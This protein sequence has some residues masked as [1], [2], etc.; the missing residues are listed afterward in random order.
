MSVTYGE[1]ES[2]ILELL[3]KSPGYSGF[4]TERKLRMAVQD[5]FDYVASHM[6]DSITGGWVDSIVYL[7]TTS[8][9]AKVELPGDFAMIS[10]VR[11]LVNSLY[12][13]LTYDKEKENIHTKPGDGISQYPSRYK[14]LGNYLYFNPPL[15]VGGTE[16]LQ[17]EGC[18][19]PAKYTDK[20][21]LI[22]SQF[23]AAFRH[24]IKY[25]SASILYASRHN[26]AKPWAHLEAQWYREIVK[27]ID[28][29][30]NTK[31]KIKEF[32]G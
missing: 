3:Q 10:T 8:N 14:L 26:G 5:C 12:V 4:Y 13:P 17:V 2:D 6:F 22:P 25:R 24:F 9:Q 16:Y 29:R 32:E 30:V 19:F 31:M 28:K 18:R 21:D 1:L 15:Q 7:D 20:Q 11:Y 27:I 23:N